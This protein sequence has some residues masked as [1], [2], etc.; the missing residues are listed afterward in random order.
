M[1]NVIKKTYRLGVDLGSTSLGWCMTELSDQN[2]P[3]G[4]IRMGVRIFPDGRDAK[5]KEPLA[6]AR[7]GYRGQ[8][9]NLDRYMLRIR[10]LV[11]YLISHGFL[12]EDDQ[13][14]QQIFKS[15]PYYLRQ[16]ALDEKLKPEE[17]ARALFH[18]AKRRGFRSNRKVLSDKKTKYSEAIENL[19][20][21][22]QEKGARTL[23]EYL[24]QKR[25][26]MIALGEH[27][28]KPLKFRYTVNPE[29]PDPI[30]PT[31]EMT[32][33]EFNMIW[34]AQAAFDPRYTQTHKEHIH[35]LIFHQRALQIPPKGK[36]QL[37]PD[38][39]RAPKAHPL[40]QEFR[41]RQDLNNLKALDV[42]EN[43]A[44]E[45]TDEQYAA[46][47][48]MLS[49]K[50]EATFEAMRKLLWGK[51]AGDYKF[52]LEANDRNKL[53]GDQAYCAFHSKEHKDL[54]ALWD[55]WD[56]DMKNRVIE[57]VISDL[58]DTDAITGLS[59]LGIAEDVAGMLL[60]VHLPS[61]YCH[62][63]VKAMQM[64]LPYMR[65]R[66]IYSQACSNAGM[67]HSGEYNGEV[68]TDGDL[69]YYGE[70]LK[71]ETIALIKKTNDPDSDAHGRINNPSVHIA[72]NQLRKVINAL[73]ESYGTP[74]EIVLELGKDIKLGLK[75]K[76][77][78][79]KLNNQNRKINETVDRFLAD[80]DIPVNSLNRLKAKLWF[81]LGKDAIDRRCVYTGHQISVT[82]LFT[83]K[84][85]VDHILPKSR[86]YDDSTANKILCLRD[87]NMYKAER[88][89]FEAFGESRDGYDWN[90]IVTRAEALPDNK[91]WRFQ[92][93][94]MQRY[95]DQEELLGRM[96]NDTRYM[97]RVA[98]KYMYYVCGKDHVWTVTG[99]HTGLLRRKW[100]LNTALGETEEKERTDHRH[101]AIDAF[102]ISLTTRSMI[103]HLADSIRQSKDRFLEKLD[104]PY[105]GF[106]HDEF[107]ALVNRI[108]VSF[109]PDHIDPHKLRQRNQTG[110]SLV[111]ETAYGYIGPAKDKPRYAEYSVRKSIDAIKVKNIPDVIGA[112]IRKELEDIAAQ[113]T[114]DDF[115]SAIK[116][117]AR[118][119]NISKVKL[120]VVAK[121]ETMVPVRD[122]D[123]KVFKYLASGEN[124]FADIYIQDPASPT[125]RWGIEIVNSYNAHTPG[126]VPQWKKD[127]PKAKKV[128][129]V[130]KNDIIALDDENGT[131][132]LKRVRKM[133]N[134]KLFLRDTTIASKPESIK[135]I[136]EQ[137]PPN[138]L[139]ACHAVKAGVDVIGRVF[140]PG[141]K[142]AN[143]TGD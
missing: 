73:C 61:D 34:D 25:C 83:R 45:I 80:S 96:L 76:E 72:L 35:D 12:P 26:E 131:R 102:V 115:P 89:P 93:E 119:R 70:V 59:K 88:G 2:E 116:N 58:D 9:R 33:H 121:P 92:A 87:A 133:T 142:H 50:K 129:R 37:L 55:S 98:M 74:Q 6:V 132:V 128:M 95:E 11:E 32:Q 17:F 62:L 97:S 36:C 28:S 86:T 13:S 38:Q 53:L 79:N 94:A 107:R 81:E 118:R 123:G 122:K 30:F 75:E 113:V 43:K 78:L 82:D 139:A 141:G 138:K 48:S 106:D 60:Q 18:L 125:P 31:R 69:P 3:I 100:G 51:A 64:I 21:A 111:E 16:K 15:D 47:F 23:G 24:Y 85:E 143:G 7:R 56:M 20:K 117:W 108:A 39:E 5:S 52:N 126:F 99:R 42:Y 44:I 130:F 65:Q 63:S 40:F 124:L 41:I 71:R 77:R 110:G 104:P 101:H 91:K 137:Y 10:G 109:K 136:G 46:L 54:S 19:A 22:L 29:E 140:D 103:K 66:I 67:D 1:K 90:A 135:D 84:I 114:E 127:Y 14:R 8:R 4:I 68:F 57:I 49:T 27:L 112:E 120:K 105:P 134:N